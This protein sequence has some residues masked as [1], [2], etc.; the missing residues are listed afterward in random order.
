MAGQGRHAFS[1]REERFVQMGGGSKPMHPRSR[2]VT[3][4]LLHHTLDTRWQRTEALFQHIYEH[5][6]GMGGYIFTS[7]L[8]TSRERILDRIDRHTADPIA[9]SGIP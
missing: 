6:L 7:L 3:S 1:P 8:E 4:C 5:K 9:K 2:F